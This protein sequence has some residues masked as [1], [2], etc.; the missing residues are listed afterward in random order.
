[1]SKRREERV[2]MVDHLVYGVYCSVSFLLS[3]VPVTWIFRGGQAVGFLGYVLLFPYRQLA[4]RNVRIAFP[5]WSPAQV[6]RCVRTHFQNLVANLVCGLV[7]REKSW[8][9]VKPFIDFGT[10]KATAEET[11]GA[12]CIVAAVTH[13]GNWELLSTLPRWMDRS[14]SGVIFQRQRNRLLD[15]RVR[16]GRSRDGMEAIDRSEGL[17]RSVGLLKRGGLLALLV[18]QHAGDKGVWVPFFH[19]LASTSTLPAILVKRTHARLLAGAMETLGSAKWRIDIRYLNLSE[20][21]SSEEIVAEL[22]Q[23]VEEQIK[24]NPADWFWLHNRWKTPSPRFLLRTYKRGIFVTPRSEPLQPFRILIRSSNW[25]GDAV[26]SV[27]AVRRIKRGR[28]DAHVTILAQR[29][30]TEFWRTVPEVDDVIGIET[31]ENAWQVA[32]KIRNR[33]EVAILFPNSPRTGLEVWLARVPRRVGYRRPWRNFFLNQFVPEPED[34]GPATHHHAQIYLQIAEHVGADM[35]EALPDIPRASGE[36]RT[37]GLCPGAE[38]GPAKRWPYFGEA[39]RILA[40]K[41]QLNWLIFGAP[42]E[43][44]LAENV[45]KQIGST[46][47]NLAGKTSLTDLV[48]ELQ[49]CQILLTNDTGTMHLAAHLRVPTVAIF[50]STEPALTGPIGEGHLVIRHQVECSPCFLRTCPIDFRCMER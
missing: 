14:I 20:N 3:L 6:E 39:A 5:D 2:T 17:S 10:V 9:R 11:A 16:R 21:A 42:G 12:Q 15:E 19:R 44:E 46:A 40:E 1:M 34:L 23:R 26:M 33:F 32:R 29:K 45:A 47:T 50:G 48:R 18:D 24:R 43:R 8:E 49:R 28:L 22:T 38:Y 4:R 27:E 37:V 25:L 41:Y 31:G 36:L 7:L 13:I 35:E 30:L